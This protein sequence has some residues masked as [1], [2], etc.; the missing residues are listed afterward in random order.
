MLR[1]PVLSSRPIRDTLF[2]YRRPAV[3]IID[4]K[5]KR[6]E[7]L[8]LHYHIVRSHLF[9]GPLSQTQRKPRILSRNEKAIDRKESAIT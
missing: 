5:D 2:R 8:P 1:N 6:R 9:S 4:T 3:F 7:A